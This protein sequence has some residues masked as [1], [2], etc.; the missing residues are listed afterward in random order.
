[1]GRALIE[2]LRDNGTPVV[3]LSSAD[4]DLTDF[5]STLAVFERHRPA[6]VYHLAARV[7]GIM[8]NLRAQGQAYLDNVRMNT[9]AVEA[10]RLSG[11]RKVVAM[12]SAAIYSDMVS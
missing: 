6:I 1:M 5:E 12:G 3:G 4:V 8:G 9:N 10:A 2:E 7:S 11:A